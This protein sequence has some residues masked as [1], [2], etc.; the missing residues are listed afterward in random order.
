MRQSTAAS[1][2]WEPT[3]LRVLLWKGR[4]EGALRRCKLFKT[5]LHPNQGMFSLEAGSLLAQEDAFKGM[6]WRHRYS[7]LKHSSRISLAFDSS[8]KMSFSWCLFWRKKKSPVEIVCGNE[9]KQE[10]SCLGEEF[11]LPLLPSKTILLPRWTTNRGSNQ[12]TFCL[13]VK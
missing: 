13:P 3:C 5:V 6:R 11:P 7:Q 8:L 12:W 9:H 2:G 10:R 4:W 1:I